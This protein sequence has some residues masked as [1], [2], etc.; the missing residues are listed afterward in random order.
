MGWLD[1]GGWWRMVEREEGEKREAVHHLL[2]SVAESA[3]TMSV[4]SAGLIMK[5]YQEFI[6]GQSP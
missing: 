6:P 3:S 2:K 4:N 1:G 5:E